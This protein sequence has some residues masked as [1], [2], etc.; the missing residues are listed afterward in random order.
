M[1][2]VVI[3][4]SNVSPVSSNQKIRLVEGHGAPG[5]CQSRGGRSL[6][7]IVGIGQADGWE[8]EGA[9]AVSGS[10]KQARH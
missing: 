4:D 1:G 5:F 3:A 8:L 10:G 2:W 9:I 7:E 6:N